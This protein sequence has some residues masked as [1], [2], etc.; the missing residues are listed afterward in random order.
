MCQ[1]S[2]YTEA[3]L[4]ATVVFLFSNKMAKFDSVPFCYQFY[5][6][7]PIES[8]DVTRS[9]YNALM[10]FCNM[11]V[12]LTALIFSYTP[13]PQPEGFLPFCA[14]NCQI[15]C[16][17][18]P[19]TFRGLSSNVQY[20]DSAYSDNVWCVLLCH[21]TVTSVTTHIFR[22]HMSVCQVAVRSKCH[23]RLS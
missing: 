11:L 1:S 9:K 14:S 22:I 5:W 16:K 8:P 15:I 12:L 18:L 20:K 17:Q 21:L 3:C 6:I 4:S 7:C 10:T 23:N 2:V 13:T 19:S